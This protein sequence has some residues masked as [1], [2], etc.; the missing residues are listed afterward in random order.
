[1]TSIQLD[2]LISLIQLPTSYYF[3]NCI[4]VFPF[5]SVS[6]F[7][8]VTGIY[9]MIPTATTDWYHIPFLDC[10]Q[11]KFN[12]NAPMSECKGVPTY[13]NF[14]RYYNQLYNNRQIQC[15]KNTTSFV[16]HIYLLLYSVWHL[17]STT[18]NWTVSGGWQ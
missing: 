18:E 10:I 5:D 17:I 7:S 3:M 9:G 15:N 8:L 14:T 12:V 2:E 11:W 1:M 13:L 4:T 6:C 16:N